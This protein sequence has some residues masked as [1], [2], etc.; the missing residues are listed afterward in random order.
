LLKVFRQ[1]VF[2]LC[3]LLV[4]SGLVNANPD[5]QYFE[6]SGIVQ[7]I[8]WEA[9]KD[10]L[11]YELRIEKRDDTPGSDGFTRVLSRVTGET[12][13]EFSLAPGEY[14]YSVIV[15]DLLGR[16]R[17]P[18]EWARLTVIPA[19]QPEIVSVNPSVITVHG[20]YSD[21]TLSIK[22]SNLVPD[23]EVFFTFAGGGEPLTFDK[24]SYI[25]SRDGKGARLRLNGL[26]LK[27]GFYDIVIKNPG[28]ITGYWRNLQVISQPKKVRPVDIS[29]TEAYNPL[30][31]LYGLLNEY[32]QQDIFPAGASLRLGINS[33]NKSY[34]VFGIES[35]VFWHYFSGTD[36]VLITGHLFSTQINLLYQ[37][38]ILRQK[39]AINVRAGG[40]FAFYLN[41]QIKTDNNLL[42]LGS[43]ALLPVASGSLS[44]TWFFHE[45]FFIELGSEFIHIFSVEK[46]QSAYIRPL[47]C[48]GFQI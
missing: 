35:Q 44:F 29:F 42:S 48:L 39:A 26:P 6:K 25:P 23:G 4:A 9:G 34:G 16:M 7:R 17:S 43:A 3:F 46:P 31:P 22:G 38:R 30:I 12:S 37:K 1:Y 15:Y 21:E 14:R 5:I 18:P 13:V 28:G 32:M 33:K 47:F 40:G 19:V 10:V 36:M 24:D 27:E 20:G 8:S 2:F 41:L 11:E 45:P